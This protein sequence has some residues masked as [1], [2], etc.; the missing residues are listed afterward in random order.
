MVHKLLSVVEEFILRNDADSII[1]TSYYCPVACR[2][3]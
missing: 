2:V 3:L 1:S